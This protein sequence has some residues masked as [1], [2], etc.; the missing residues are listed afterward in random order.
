M[1]YRYITYEKS[2][3]IVTISMN[4]PESLNA[5]HPAANLEMHEAFINFGALHMQLVDERRENPKDDLL[6]IWVNAEIDGQKLDEDDLLF[7]H[8]MMMIGGSETAR[9][10]RRL[11]HP[12][13]SPIRTRRRR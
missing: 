2:D 9:N 6:S 8:T 5:L 13:S 7:E 10:A 11:S 1:S 4:R 12:C 3:R